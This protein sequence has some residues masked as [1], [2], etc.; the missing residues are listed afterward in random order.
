[1]NVAVRPEASSDLVSAAAYFHDISDGWGD[2][3]LDALEIDLADR[4]SDAGIHAIQYDY[5][6]SSPMYSRLQS[7]TASRLSRRSSTRP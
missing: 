2:H 1:M 3:F 4:R 6:P 5:H 7:T